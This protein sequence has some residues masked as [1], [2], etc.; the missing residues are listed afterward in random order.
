MSDSLTPKISSL[1]SYLEN[2][3]LDRIT[4]LEFEEELIFL[5]SILRINLD[6]CNL[7][8]RLIFS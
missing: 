5:S 2:L 3:D 6:P 1:R 7:L 8:L 4:C